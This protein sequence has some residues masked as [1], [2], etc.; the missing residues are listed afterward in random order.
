[1]AS[2]SS[3]RL[4]QR[5]VGLFLAATLLYHALGDL[6]P[7]MVFRVFPD[8]LCLALVRPFRAI[9]TVLRPLVW[10]ASGIA[11]RLLRW[12]GA[13]ESAARLLGNRDELRLIIQES[14]QD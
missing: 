14:E 12:G 3:G 1:M 13:Q 7:K 2:A 6:L 5:T 8:R 11:G 9:H 10:L 4:A